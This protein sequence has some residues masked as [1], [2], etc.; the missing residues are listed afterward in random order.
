MDLAAGLA[1]R[2]IRRVFGTP[3]MNLYPERKLTYLP[4]YDYSVPRAYFI[5]ACTINRDFLFET[6][7]AILAIESAWCSVLDI[8][9]NIELDEFVVM[10]NHVHGI[11]WTTGEVSYGYHLGTWNNDIQSIS[12]EPAQFESINSIIRAFKT[13]ATVL[14]HQL[15]RFGETPVWQTGFYNQIIRNDRELERIQKYIRNNPRN[16]TSDRDNSAGP[17]FRPPAKSIDDYWKE[18]FHSYRM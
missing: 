11:V 3:I 18:I 17:N 2:N 1:D 6:T 4:D 14:I 10:P 15:G 12:T 13:T 16:W 8:F 5:T 7:D 9:A